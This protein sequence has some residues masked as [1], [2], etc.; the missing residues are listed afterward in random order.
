VRYVEF[1]P[2][3]LQQGDYYDNCFKLSKTEFVTSRNVLSLVLINLIPFL[4][5][6]LHIADLLEVTNA[7]GSYPFGRSINAIGSIYTTQS[8][9]VAYCNIQI[10]L[11]LSLIDIRLFYQKY[12]KAYL[13]LLAI[14]FLLFIYPIMT[15]R[16]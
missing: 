16:D 3:I 7:P 2:E 13:M 5:V 10:V 14:N 11:L 12:N 15:M 1:S 6:L 9:Y 4:L 8:A